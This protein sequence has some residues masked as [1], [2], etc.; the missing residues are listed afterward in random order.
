MDDARYVDALGVE[1]R[2]VLRD[3]PEPSLTRGGLVHDG[4]LLD[5]LNGETTYATKR[6]E[7][8]MAIGDTNA[9]P[10]RAVL[11]AEA[12]HHENQVSRNR[13]GA[14]A[15]SCP[16][17]RVFARSSSTASRD[18]S[19]SARGPI[20][21]GARSPPRWSDS[22]PCSNRRVPTL[23]SSSSW[24]PSWTPPRAI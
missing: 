15:A 13:D 2:E 9:V 3:I 18:D 16:P 8:P 23:S 11:D 14:V 6:G 10:M 17:S 20:A 4:A 24:N 5:A 19:I 22:R 12:N 21:P 1:H 7:V